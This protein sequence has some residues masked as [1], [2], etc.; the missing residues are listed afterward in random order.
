MDPHV[1]SW[2]SGRAVPLA[3]LEAG[4][5][6]GDLAPLRSDLAGTRVIGLGEATHGTREFFTLK[7]RLLEFLVTDMGFTVLAMEASESASTV[8]NDYV[9]HG[10]GQAGECL[11][12]L[13]FWTWNTYE[14]LGVLEWLQAHNQHVEPSRRVRFVGIDPQIP[15]VAVRTVEVFLRAAGADPRPGVAD[16]LARLAR[17][18]LNGPPCDP[19]VRRDIVEID[20]LLRSNGAELIDRT[21]PEQYVQACRHAGF[22]LRSAELVLAPRRVNAEGE[23]FYAVRDRLMAQ[24]VAAVAGEPDAPRIAVWAH[25]GHVSNRGEP[26]PTM[27]SHLRRW[28]GDEYYAL[29]LL[30]GSGSF[31]ARRRRLLGRRRDPVSNRVGPAPDM[32]VEAQL[33]A[34]H[35][36]HHVVDL[37]DADAPEAA[38]RWLGERGWV[39][40]YGAEVRGLTYA[41]SFAP[42]VPGVEYD[43]L[44]YV[45]SARA[46]L[47]R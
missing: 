33:A 6:T 9:L 30:L 15:A 21:S 5:P 19:V 39:R 23:S 46:S 34:A 29:G 37:R 12:G 42:T 16:S 20:E 11:D 36:G 18:R 22:L 44:A 17:T 4:A 8:V 1:T 28:L 7:H 10:T 43:G 38:R 40:S 47:A 25:N 24:A 14:V 32:T 2:L 26:I 27:G 31:R 13:G 45:H 3:S 41:T 35:P